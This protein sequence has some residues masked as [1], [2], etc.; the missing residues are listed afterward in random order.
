MHWLAKNMNSLQGTHTNV[1]FLLL[2][3]LCFCIDSALPLTAYIMTRQKLQDLHI[4]VV[5]KKSAMSALCT[6]LVPEM[7][8]FL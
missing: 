3:C 4:E 8:L 7:L 5:L 2:S 6:L 1:F